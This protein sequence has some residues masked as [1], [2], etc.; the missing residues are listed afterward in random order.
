[1]QLHYVRWTCGEV[2][3]SID[4]GNGWVH[5][6]SHW[7]AQSNWSFVSNHEYF[8]S[9]AVCFNHGFDFSDDVGVDT[10]AETFIGG[11]GAEQPLFGS[12]VGFLFGEIGLVL[13]DAL[14]G[15]YS[16]IFGSFKST[17]ILLHFGGSHH[18]HSL[19][20]LVCT[21]V[22]FLMDSTAFILILI[23][24]RFLVAK[25]NWLWKSSE[26][27]FWRRLASIIN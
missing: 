13:D 8:V 15:A 4:V 21:L 20:V 12:E 6:V 11:D 3:G 2:H 24:L 19:N 23:C 10:T 18:L 27:A 7:S 25:P 1:M 22:I 5:D 9:T 14:Y 16:I 26:D 17:D